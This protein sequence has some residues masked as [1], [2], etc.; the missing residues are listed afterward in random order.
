MKEFMSL[1][2]FLL[3]PHD[4]VSPW[5]WR[6]LA[7]GHDFVRRYDI[8]KAS[9]E[10]YGDDPPP[11]VLGV[12]AVSPSVDLT[13]SAALILRRSNWI[14]QQD[15]V[16]RLKKRI[17]TKNQLYPEL[18]DI[19]GLRQVRTLKQFDER[20]T[21][22]AHGF[23][24]ADDYYYR[25]SAIRVIDRIRIPTLII[26]AEDDPFI[27]FAPLKDPAVVNNPHILLAGTAQGGH[28]GFISADP[29]HE[30]SFWA[31]NRIVEF[32]KLAIQ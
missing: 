29:N 9:Y 19:S 10:K 18:Y 31:E 17:R 30:D 28:V 15:F 25:S 26:H 6:F 4:C 20:F 7:E 12:C 13:A 16:R 21:A 1:R 11:E 2:E 23:A 14:Y 22:P 24:G 3:Q 8:A 5:P 27:P 32:C